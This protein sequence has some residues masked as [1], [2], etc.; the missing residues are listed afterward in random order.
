M[1]SHCNQMNHSVNLCKLGRNWSKEKMFLQNLSFKVHELEK[2]L[3][4]FIIT[5]VAVTHYFW[6]SFSK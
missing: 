2:K 3:M 6:R 1:T 5:G 4:I